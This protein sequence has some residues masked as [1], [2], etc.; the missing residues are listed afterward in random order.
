MHNFAVINPQ[1]TDEQCFKW[2]ILAKYL[3]GDNK[4]RV[5]E[6]RPEHEEKYD[7]CGLTFPTPLNEIKIFEKKTLA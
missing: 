4:E 5:G 3:T 6:N 2:M 7:F 1:N